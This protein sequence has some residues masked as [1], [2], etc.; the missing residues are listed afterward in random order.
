MEQTPGQFSLPT[1]VR[2]K[3][4]KLRRNEKDARIHKRLSAL[5]WLN[6]GYSPDEVADLLDACPR[7]VKSWVALYQAGGLELL[8]RLDYQGDPG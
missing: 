1:L 6:K 2:K 3:V 7:T 4:E 8:C 5:L